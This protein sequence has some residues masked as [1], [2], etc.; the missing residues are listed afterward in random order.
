MN[1]LVVIGT[2]PEAVKMAPVVH[3]LR[4]N[5]AAFGRVAVCLTAQHRLLSDQVLRLFALRPDHDLD[6]MTEGQTIFD[7]TRRVL[8]GMRPV[9]EAERPDA[10]LVHGD[11]TTTF[12]AALASYYCRTPVAHVEAGLRTHHPY[13]PFPEEMNRRLADALC[14][15][16]YAPTPAAR[17]NLLRENI[18]DSGIVVTGNTVIDALLY[19]AE[20]PCEHPFIRALPR[21]RRIVVLTAHRRESF[22]RPLEEIFEAAREIADNHADVLIVAPVHPNPAVRETAYRIAGGHPRIRLAEPMEYLPFVHL[23]KQSYLILSDSGGIQEEAPSLKKPVLV[24]REVTE[25]PEAIAAGTAR[26][27]GPH[28][29]AIVRETT[30]LLE[31]P[32]A[33]AAMIRSDNPFGDGQAA[34]RIARHLAEQ[35]S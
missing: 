20:R 21:D 13:Q 17:D 5:T 15:W 22:G 26:I 34:G 7:I 9:L 27:V 29:D 18:P 23:L 33:Y 31:D 28:R 8:D 6:I 12:A 16:H 10:V 30:R 2:R 24:L 11:T 35:A 25:R 32:A 3:A 19:V 4:E 1:I 14:A